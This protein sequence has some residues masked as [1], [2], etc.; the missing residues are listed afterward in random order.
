MG[1]RCYACAVR[2]PMKPSMKCLLVINASE[3]RHK[4]VLLP[5]TA[6]KYRPGVE[7]VDTITVL[8][9]VIDQAALGG[10]EYSR[11]FHSGLATRAAQALGMKILRNP[12]ATLRFIQQLGDRENHAGTLPYAQISDMNQIF[13]IQTQLL[14]FYF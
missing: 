11:S 12:A 7:V 8:A 5:P 1:I 9:A 2:S 13:M 14:N 10:T 4:Q 6:C 3:N